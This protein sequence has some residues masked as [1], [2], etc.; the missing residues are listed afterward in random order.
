MKIKAVKLV[1]HHD[2][3]DVN[4]EK[5]PVLVP[6]FLVT[7]DDSE[8]PL[9]VPFDTMNMDYVDVATW[10]EAQKKK[11]FKFDFENAKPE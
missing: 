11:P 10:Y 3:P 5:M 4:G 6:H 8:A 1:T 9:R 7:S 2:Q